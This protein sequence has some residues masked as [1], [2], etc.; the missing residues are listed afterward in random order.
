MIVREI[1]D[2]KWA[3]KAHPKE[4]AAA[5]V[6]DQP[7]FL[8]KMDQDRAKTPNRPLCRGFSFQAPFQMIWKRKTDFAPSFVFFRNPVFASASK[9]D[10]A[11]SC[12][13]LNCPS[14]IPSAF[15]RSLNSFAYGRLN[16]LQLLIDKI[17]HRAL[18]CLRRQKRQAIFSW[19]T[20][21]DS[22]NRHLV[23]KPITLTKDAPIKE[24]ER[25]AHCRA[26]RS[27]VFL[28][29]QRVSFLCPGMGGRK[30]AKSGGCPKIV[31][32]NSL[33]FPWLTR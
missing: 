30:L 20:T 26:K 15:R 2:G 11:G 3:A 16:H 31:D 7:E 23:Q 8:T 18:V 33:S 29:Y 9:S 14:R 10:R 27:Y 17:A 28:L 5:A 12:R 13:R 1:A 21:N 4:G 32:Y 25:T 19:R 6:W 24:R 22:R